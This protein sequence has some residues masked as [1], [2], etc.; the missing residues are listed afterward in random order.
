VTKHKH[1]E[2]TAAQ[3]HAA[4]K[5]VAKKPAEKHRDA[6]K[7][8][9]T[10]MAHIISRT[11][12]PEIAF[13]SSFI[14]GHYLLN[15]DF[16]YPSEIIIPIIF[17]G[18][19][20]TVIFYLMRLVVKSWLGARV[21][22]LALVYALYSYSY[23]PGWLRSS[24]GVF[25]PKHFETA[26]S[27]ATLSVII[28]AVLCAGLGYGVV[29]LSRQFTVIKNLQL[30][31]IVLFAVLFI[32]AIQ[33]LKVA[34][35]ISTIHRQLA[36]QYPKPEL[37][38]APG[39]AVTEP[40]IYYFVFDRY[41][42]NETLKKV[43]DFDNNPLTDYLA[44]QGFVNRL[45][46]KTNYPFTMESVSSTLAMDYHTNLMKLF[47]NAK[48][49]TAFPYRSILSNPPIAQVLKENGYIYNQV[50]SWWDFTR[51]GIKADGNQTKSF[52]L[53]ALGKNFYL[54]DLTRDIVNKSILSP[55]LKKGLTFGKTMVL[56]YDNDNN[57]RQNFYAQEAAV[58]AIASSPSS[59][60]QFTFAHFL[61]PH[62]PYIFDADGSDPSYDGGRNDS[63]E[64]EY[65]KYRQEITYLNT[66]IKDMM[67]YIRLH[68]PNAAIVIQ[69]DEGP[70]PKE[71]RFALTPDHYYNPSNLP[72]AQERQKYGILASYYMP[73]VD[74]ATVQ[75]NITASVNPFRFIL[76]QYLGYDIEM[77]PDC[78]FATGDKYVIYKY[79]NETPKLQTNP[80]A[81]CN[82]L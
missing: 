4:K 60:P 56:K 31:K 37:K 58:K 35:K 43:Y 39:A 62:D 28:L 1:Q 54:S 80:T 51:V 76:K 78:Q 59:V 20:A 68:S 69:S 38:R 27:N 18:V 23:L 11:S 19:I 8:F 44:G 74:A 49:Q 10:K 47:G 73:G 82:S 52:R 26:F 70:Y 48:Y 21:A 75:A 40:D 36:Y 57:P 22:S 66:Q 34:N 24:G 29:R 6:L 15:A 41:G 79:E 3:K 65:V 55:W 12:L 7:H 81:A 33:G 25:L 30:H 64:D 2:K 42:N 9:G 13:I 63:G 32:F 67:S 45:D 77:L 5:P 61:A 46:A 16:Q 14:F 53:R 50:S 71:F 17:F 72:L